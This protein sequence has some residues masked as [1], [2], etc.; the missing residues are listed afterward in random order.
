[1]GQ[2][3]PVPAWGSGKECPPVLGARVDSVILYRTAGDT[4]QLWDKLPLT[5]TEDI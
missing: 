2:V 4:A 1:M 3:N 5:V